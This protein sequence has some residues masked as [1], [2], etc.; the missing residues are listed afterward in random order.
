MSHSDERYM[1]EIPATEVPS[2]AEAKTLVRRNI[3]AVMQSN[4]AKRKEGIFSFERP[5]ELFTFD[6]S[7][8]VKRVTHAPYR[9]FY[10]QK[11]RS[12]QEKGNIVLRGQRYLCA[13]D[14][15]MSFH[16]KVKTLG[17][18]FH[19]G[20]DTLMADTNPHEGDEQ[21]LLRL[22]AMDYVKNAAITLFNGLVSPEKF[23][24]FSLDDQAYQQVRGMASRLAKLST[25][26]QYAYMLG[27]LQEAQSALVM[28]NTARSDMSYVETYL[29]QYAYNAMENGDKRAY[30]ILSRPELAHPLIVGGAAIN[31]VERRK[32]DVPDTIV[33]LP[34]G[35][36]EF[37]YV[38]Q[39]GFQ[40]LHGKAPT[41][42]LAP[43]S[44]HGT[45][46]HS[47]LERE[48]DVIDAAT[49]VAS[50]EEMQELKAFLKRQASHF[51]G[52]SVLIADDNSASGK[53]LQ[54]TADI[55][56]YMF[57]PKEIDA[58]VAETDVI[59]M[60]LK[61]HK[62][63]G[64][65]P[66]AAP[67]PVTTEAARKDVV[68]ILPVSQELQSNTDIRKLLEFRRVSRFYDE[69]ERGKNLAERVLH[70]VQRRAALTSAKEDFERDPNR[71][72][73]IYSFANSFLSNFEPV[74]VEYAIPPVVKGRAPRK[75][76]LKRYPSVEHA[77]QGAKFPI[78]AARLIPPEVFTQVN[79]V[80][81]DRYGGRDGSGWRPINTPEELVAAFTNTFYSPGQLKIFSD[82]LRNL[83][84]IRPDWFNIRT[85]VM[86][87]L[88]I[89]K[90]KD[91]DLK[92]KLL[93]TGR[94]YLAEG[95]LWGDTYW[96]VA[97]KPQRGL[98][99]GPNVMKSGYG[100]NMLGMLLMELRA[101]L[102][103][104]GA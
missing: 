96:G 60:E 49:K 78:E 37:A 38:L 33:G 54:L 77:Y 92:D 97:M 100:S 93:A 23:G 18:D 84:Y 34:T 22:G 72:E 71:S 53:T 17:E 102:Q 66:N 13:L 25:Q 6:G 101:Q 63:G 44:I 91:P 104:P 12:A 41:L 8:R 88:L 39:Y 15:N 45:R 58:T 86:T 32:D 47:N 65:A 19:D 28:L 75:K 48:E 83:G 69:G 73:G 27:D 40:K 62:L 46:I 98:V 99:L 26:M 43:I 80:M 10:E 81:Y 87:D 57:G 4:I 95:N 11:G 68:G 9:K 35:G 82:R 36:T 56:S 16:H 52:T 55:L 76:G 20:L 31:V 5:D 2:R 103:Q 7:V 59:R 29:S 79:A 51:K 1:R 42:I 3:E 24:Q 90:F 70:N 67:Y 64:K 94:K 89:E 50:D 74:V 30:P 61:L 21:F 85:Q 14:G